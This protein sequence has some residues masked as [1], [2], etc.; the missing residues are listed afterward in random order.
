MSYK[1]Q[2]IRQQ[3]QARKNLF[4]VTTLKSYKKRDKQMTFKDVLTTCNVEHVSD[5]NDYIFN[6]KHI[7]AIDKMTLNLIYEIIKRLEKDINKRVKL[8]N[9]FSDKYTRTLKDIIEVK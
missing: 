6:S 2:Y 4:K 8:F 7:K 9:Y 3:E 1:E 5:T